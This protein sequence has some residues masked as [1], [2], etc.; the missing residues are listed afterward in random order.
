MAVAETRKEEL[1]AGPAPGG[2]SGD[3]VS[4]GG[5]LAVGLVR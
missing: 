3:P 1:L 4:S 2:E 5:W